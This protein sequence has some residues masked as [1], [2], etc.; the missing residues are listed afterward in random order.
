MDH[1]HALFFLCEKTVS[2]RLYEKIDNL[3]L[4]VLCIC[5]IISFADVQM[6]AYKRQCFT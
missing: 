1:F 2:E 4:P 5:A 3:P 6:Y